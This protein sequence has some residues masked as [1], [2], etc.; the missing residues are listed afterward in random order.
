MS[1]VKQS[2]KK[3]PDP[4]KAVIAVALFFVCAAFMIGLIVLPDELAKVGDFDTLVVGSSIGKWGINAAV[5]TE[6]TDHKVINLSMGPSPMPARVE[7][8]EGAVKRYHPKVILVEVSFESWLNGDMRAWSTVNATYVVSRMCTAE[9]AAK[10][11]IQDVQVPW[12]DYNVVWGAE[13][14][15]AYNAWNHVLHGNFD[16]YKKY[17]GSGYADKTANLL[18]DAERIIN[19]AKNNVYPEIRLVYNNKYFRELLDLCRDSGARTILVNCPASELYRYYNPCLQQFYGEMSAFA[20]EYDFEYYDFNLY[21]DMQNILSDSDSFR[22]TVHL[23]G[24]SSLKF[25]EVLAKEV[26]GKDREDVDFEEKSY[27]SYEDYRNHSIYS[28]IRLY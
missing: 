12:Y 25:S 21:K 3:I 26:L 22:D 24:E 13:A 19:E 14:D 15:A 20:Q 27:E 2:R 18:D 1:E 23:N 10:Y 5:L 7:V 6:N 4:L 28:M 17:A 11:L 9:T 8:L 16:T